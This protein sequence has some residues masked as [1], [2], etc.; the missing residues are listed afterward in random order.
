MKRLR[1]TL[2]ELL[3]VIAIIAILAGMLL[4]TLNRARDKAKEIG[5]LNNIK[6]TGTVVMQY[7]LDYD[8]WAPPTYTDGNSRTWCSTL[9]NN[10][11]IVRNPNLF[12]CPAYPPYTY[13]SSATYGMF[14]SDYNKCVRLSGKFKQDAQTGKDADGQTYYV[15]LIRKGPSK[16]LVFGDSR[17]N[18]T[19]TAGKTQSYYALGYH[20]TVRLFHA[21]HAGRMNGF[22]ADGHGISLTTGELPEIG[23]QYCIKNDVAVKTW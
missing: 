4:P 18:I 13:N 15:P 8:G 19:N 7:G 9:F 11:Y 21:R 2:I 14:S 10:G 12:V 5:C 17:Q 22:F 6:Q 20:A 3:V 16:H 23:V 1:F